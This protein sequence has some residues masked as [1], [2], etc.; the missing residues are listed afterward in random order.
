MLPS[1][2]PFPA[3]LVGFLALVLS[4]C[5]TWKPSPALDPT[6]AGAFEPIEGRA[7]ITLTDGEQFEVQDMRVDG[8]TLH[9]VRVTRIPQESTRD[10]PKYRR[11]PMSVPVKQVVRVEGREFSAWRTGVAVGVAALIATIAAYAAAA[12]SWSGSWGSSGSG[13]WIPG[14]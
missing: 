4:G 1:R 12:S 11:E 10:L 5:S 6:A 13:G 8:D 9:A 2:F 3:L 14:Q 7:R